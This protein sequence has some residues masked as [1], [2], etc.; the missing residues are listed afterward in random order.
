MSITCVGTPNLALYSLISSCSTESTSVKIKPISILSAI[1]FA[2]YSLV[3]KG[4]DYFLLVLTSIPVS[5][6][7]SI[8]AILPFGG[9]VDTSLELF[10]YG[11]D[12]YH[13]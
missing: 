13:L 12:K 4:T 9:I 2:V 5:N 10:I 7:V 1:D 8:G 6:S 11:H 3:A